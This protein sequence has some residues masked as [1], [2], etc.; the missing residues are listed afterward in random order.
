MNKGEITISV[1]ADYSIDKSFLH[2]MANYL[3]DRQHYVQI[4]NKKSSLLTV[5]FGVPQGSILG[6][7]IFNLI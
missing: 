7:V 6:P 5:G 1:S 4:E 2:W 3:S